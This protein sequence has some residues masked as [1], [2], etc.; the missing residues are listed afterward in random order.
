MSNKILKALTVEKVNHLKLAFASS[1]SVFW[2]E[3]KGNLI[4]AG[5]YGVYRERAVQ[6]LLNLYTPQQ[7]GIGTGFIIT[8]QGSVSTQC[9]IVVYD[10]SKMP[11]IITESHQVFYPVESVVAVCEVKSDINS[12]SELNKYLTK[13]SKV[14]ALREEITNPSPYRSYRDRVYN[15]KSHPYDQIFTLLICNKFNFEN[16]LSSVQ[17]NENIAPRNRHNLVLSILDGLLCYTTDGPPV[18]HYP[19]SGGESH[20]DHWIK[21]TED[22][23]S[24]HFKILLTSFYNA[25]NTITLLDLDMVLYLEDNP[26]DKQP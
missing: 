4:H 20:K 2:N 15:P 5:E 21:A 24:A 6:Q 14:K 25:M 23:L 13:L 11:A 7:F 10:K 17:H 22:E 18:F 3:D 26:Y 12:P 1:K 19:V 8:N 9:D 16:T